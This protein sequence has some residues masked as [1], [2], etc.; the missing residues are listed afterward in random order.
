[1]VTFCLTDWLKVMNHRVSDQTITTISV[2]QS[3]MI[4]IGYS[5]LSWDLNHPVIP[6]VPP[7]IMVISSEIMRG[8]CKDK[9]IIPVTATMAMITRQRKTVK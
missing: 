1:M 2:M 9:G 8:G 7:I 6:I 5:F 4:M 3:V